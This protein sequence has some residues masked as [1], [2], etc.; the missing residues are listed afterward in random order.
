MKNYNQSAVTWMRNQLKAK[1]FTSHNGRGVFECEVNNLTAKELYNKALQK[2]DMWKE[3]EIIES[4]ENK[5]NCLIVKLKDI[6]N[7][8]G[9]N[10]RT[11]CFQNNLKS[12]SCLFSC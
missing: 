8:A 2:I 10:Y 5:D 4:V 9:K 6:F 12:Y 11:F 7:E 1:G 3:K